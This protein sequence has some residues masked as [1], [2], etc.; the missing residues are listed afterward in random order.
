MTS[1]AASGDDRYLARWPITTPSSTSQSV[2]SEPR[3]TCISSWGPTMQWGTFVNR[4]DSTGT[5][6]PVSRTRSW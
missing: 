3:G 2:F 1:I 5:V 6:A 4:I